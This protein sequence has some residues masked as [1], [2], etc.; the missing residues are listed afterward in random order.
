MKDSCT[1]CVTAQVFSSIIAL[2][3]ISM[4]IHHLIMLTLLATK[5][6]VLGFWFAPIL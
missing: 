5:L 3:G 6:S 4:T 2:H 1:V